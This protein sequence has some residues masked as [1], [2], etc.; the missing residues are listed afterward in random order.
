MRGLESTKCA[1][2]LLS[3]AKG[4]KSTDL[5]PA[6]APRANWSCQKGAGGL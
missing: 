6:G 3:Y 5:C 4:T 2:L 1:S